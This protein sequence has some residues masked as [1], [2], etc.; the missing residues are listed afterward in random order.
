MNEEERKE[1]ERA[2]KI[3]FYR[4]FGGDIDKII[5]II[6]DTNKNGVFGF[7]VYI[8][9]EDDPSSILGRSTL[10]LCRKVDEGY[11]PWFTNKGELY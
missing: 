11:A 7:I 2:L 6:G 8:D 5:T 3:G 10:S 9:A 1:V 4:I